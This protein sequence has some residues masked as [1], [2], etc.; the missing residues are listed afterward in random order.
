MHLNSFRIAVI[1]AGTGLLVKCKL[2]FACLMSLRWSRW[3]LYL[4]GED[5]IIEIHE[6]DEQGSAA[7][8]S[9]GTGSNGPDDGSPRGQHPAD[10]DAGGSSGKAS[11][12]KA[13]PTSSTTQ[14]AAQTDRTAALQKV[15]QKRF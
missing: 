11:P 4:I 6:D 1:S 13:S 15:A 9:Q 2:D 3:E 7:N 10:Q 12:G 14:R 8:G 5:A